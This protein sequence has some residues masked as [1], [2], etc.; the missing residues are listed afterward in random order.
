MLKRTEMIMSAASDERCPRKT[1]L[2]SFHGPEP[3]AALDYTADLKILVFPVL[4]PGKSELRGPPGRVPYSRNARQKARPRVL[5]EANKLQGRQRNNA[6]RV[7]A[8]RRNSIG[9]RDYSREERSGS[10]L[11]DF[12]KDAP[13]LLPG[14]EVEQF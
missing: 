11:F 7:S 10:R 1:R 9:D 6:R 14:S 12:S 5:K 3:L 4:F 8:P 13:N 2:L